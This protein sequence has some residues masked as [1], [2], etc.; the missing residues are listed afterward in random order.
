[1]T[2]LD[3]I[4][5]GRD[6]RADLQQKLLSAR[7]DA[8]VCQIALNIPG[9]PK[10]VSGDTKV[11][12]DCRDFL[13]ASLSARPFEEH[14]IENGAGFC[15]QGG[16]CAVECDARKFKLAALEAEESLEAGRLLDVDVI[17]SEGAISRRDMGLPPRRC[18]ICES[19]AKRCARE[20]RHD[21]AEL[22]EIAVSI[23][24]KAA[25]PTQTRR[26]NI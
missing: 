15:W 6:E 9:Y 2:P 19:E 13:L 21:A 22:R 1:M 24:K 7:E 16:F 5:A 26:D 4:L 3:E 12:E 17:T 25:S 18:L 10:R 8:F 20:G 23:I 11:I 14:Y